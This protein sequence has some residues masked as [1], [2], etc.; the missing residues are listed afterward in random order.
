MC[1]HKINIDEKTTRK[2]NTRESKNISVSPKLK[3]LKQEIDTTI[4]EIKSKFDTYNMLEKNNPK[5]ANDILRSQVFFILSLL[6]F[7]IHE[8]VRISLINIFNDATA[9]NSKPNKYKEISITL[10]DLDKYK[11][12]DSN[13]EWFDEII[14]KKHSFQTFVGKE[15]MIYAL[16]LIS[17]DNLLKK[18][19]TTLGKKNR[20]ELLDEIN[21]I[22]KRRNKIAHQIDLLHGTLEKISITKTEVENYIDTIEKF[23]NALHSEI[24]KI[25]I[26]T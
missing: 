13:S 19:A 17:N 18:V 2:E 4:F 1:K 7:Y 20:E 8:S 12:H 24:S 25:N 5:E 3:N 11:S 10:N 26:V 16:N 21:L 22:Y 15:Q 6:D 14:I 23:I 9:L